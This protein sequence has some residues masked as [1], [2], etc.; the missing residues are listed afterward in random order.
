MEML[1]TSMGAVLTAVTAAVV[2]RPIV[3]LLAFGIPCVLL[4]ARTRKRRPA[5]PDTWEAHVLPHGPLVTI[6]E[7]CLWCVDGTLKRGPNVS[8][9]GEAWLGW[10]MLCLCTGG[11]ADNRRVMCSGAWW[12]SDHLVRV[13]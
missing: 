11:C 10:C 12:C 6:V 7:G 9:R 5:K 4:M 8:A 13:T 3:A 1:R 2:E